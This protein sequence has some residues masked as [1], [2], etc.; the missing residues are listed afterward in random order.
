MNLG[1]ISEEFL[2]EYCILLGKSM[3]GNVDA[4]LLWLRL[5]D[6]YLVKKM[7]PKKDQGGLLYH[8]KEI[9]KREVG[10]CNVSPCVRRIHGW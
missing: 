8:L 1:I 10:T 7:Q 2:R 3:Y 4:D 6:K 9:L 5:L